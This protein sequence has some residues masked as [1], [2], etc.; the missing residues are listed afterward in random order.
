MSILDGILDNTTQLTGTARESS[1]QDH[2]LVGKTADASNEFWTEG[3]TKLEFV[4]CVLNTS[5]IQ[6][7]FSLES[8]S[9]IADDDNDDFK[10]T[11]GGEV[12]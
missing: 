10:P 7:L 5:E 11:I 2:L 9:P 8:L 1:L 3:S 6:N 12:D 4:N